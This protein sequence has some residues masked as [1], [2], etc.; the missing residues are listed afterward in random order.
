MIQS[1]LRPELIVNLTSS[2]TIR[3]LVP[4]TQLLPHLQT[5]GNQVTANWQFVTAM[6]IPGA[7]A[8]SRGKLRAKFELCAAKRLFNRDG[9]QYQVSSDTDAHLETAHGGIVV[10]DRLVVADGLWS[11]PEGR[12]L[13]A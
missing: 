2:E 6:A 10:I 4:T 8:D 9:A 13:G 7:A 1:A 12:Q 11:R 5:F 3:P